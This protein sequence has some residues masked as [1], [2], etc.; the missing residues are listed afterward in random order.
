LELNDF[1]FIAPYNA[2]ERH[3]LYIQTQFP[4]VQRGLS[5]RQGS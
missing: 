1:L 2:Q 3:E 5:Q 4:F